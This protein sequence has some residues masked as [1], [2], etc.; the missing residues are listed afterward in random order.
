[1]SRFL[2]LNTLLLFLILLQPLTAS[3]TTL[4]RASS[5]STSTA[6]VTD[7]ATGQ[8]LLIDAEKLK[9]ISRLSLPYP[10]HRKIWQ[11]PMSHLVYLSSPH[12]WVIKVDLNTTQILQQLQ[13]GQ[14]TSGIALSHDGRFLMAANMVPKTLVA[15]DTENF[16]IIRTLD[17]KDKK[18]K[19]L[20][21]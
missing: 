8:A 5:G 1:V 21:C 2:A 15:I 6:L 4:A 20:Q 12:G 3:P 9:I 10:L 16:A 11:V 7:A 13:V 17:V 14:S 18:V 19:D